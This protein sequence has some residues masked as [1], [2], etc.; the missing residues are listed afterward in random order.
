MIFSPISSNLIYLSIT[1]PPSP[2]GNDLDN[3][4][5]AF[6]HVLLPRSSLL[7]RYAEVSAD[8]Q[9]SQKIKGMPVFHMVGQRLFTGRVAVA[10]ARCFFNSH[11]LFSYTHS[12][13]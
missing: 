3:A 13:S 11:S 5:I 8:G 6:D 4:W 10:Q 7:S 12:Q 1:H 9:Y 2:V